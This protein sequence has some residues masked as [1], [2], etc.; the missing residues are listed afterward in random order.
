MHHGSATTL[1]RHLYDNL[2]ATAKYVRERLYIPE[3]KCFVHAPVPWRRQ[4]TRNGSGAGT[5][6][7]NVLLMNVLLTGNKESKDIALSTLESMLIRREVYYSPIKEGNDPDFPDAKS[8]AMGIYF[9]PF[10]I[11]MLH[12]LDVVMPEIKYDLTPYDVWGGTETVKRQ[13]EE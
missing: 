10:T 3:R 12:K 13:Q 4:S 5:S 11:D 9:I 8:V 6:L 1:D 7:R 2:D